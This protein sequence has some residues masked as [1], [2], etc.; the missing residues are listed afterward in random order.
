MLKRIE[1]VYWD[2][3]EPAAGSIQE[4]IAGVNKQDEEM[5][6]FIEELSDED[7]KLFEDE[8]EDLFSESSKSDDEDEGDDEDGDKKTSKDDEDDVNPDGDDSDSNDSTDDSDD[9]LNK[10]KDEEE[11]KESLDSPEVA[12]LKL[13][14]AELK[15]MISQLASPKS[16]EDTEPKEIKDPKLDLKEIFEKA[17]FEKIIDNK[18]KFSEFLINVISAAQSQYHTQLV[19]TLPQVVN[20]TVQNANN[21]EKM[22]NAFY[23]KHPE[24]ELVKEYVGNVAA[25]LANV[26]ENQNLSVEELMEKAAKVS[27]EKLG[28]K[29]K[30]KEENDQE[31]PPDDEKKENGK[32]EKKAKLPGASGTRPKGEQKSGLEKEMDELFN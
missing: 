16:D 12:D 22:R 11:R 32:N 3:D 6:P 25:G 13:Q 18:D 29:D 15:G 27:K 9:D 21:Y 10:R 24:L 8:V 14:I 17:D 2:Q 30:A 20:S 4:I 5:S 1:K 26:L 31:T 23:E 28:I 19:D 7:V